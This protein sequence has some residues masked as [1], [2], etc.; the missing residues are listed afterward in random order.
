MI[1]YEHMLSQYRTAHTACVGSGDSRRDLREESDLQH[2]K[3]H[4]SKRHGHL[5]TCGRQTSEHT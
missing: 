3:H 4:I 5:E 2:A 1:W